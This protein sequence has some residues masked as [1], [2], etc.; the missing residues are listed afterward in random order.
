VPEVNID[1]RIL[2]KFRDEGRILSEPKTVMPNANT[3]GQGSVTVRLVN[4]RTPS[5]QDIVR[6]P[7]PP[8]T[9]NLFRGGTGKGR[10]R[11]Q[12][13]NDWLE[14]ALPILQGMR[15]PPLTPFYLKITIFDDGSFSQQS[16]CD[17]RIKACQDALVK[18]GVIPGDSVGDGLHGVTVRYMRYTP[19]EG[20]G[21]GA[22][23]QVH[24]TEASD[25]AETE[26]D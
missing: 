18:A 15:G 4:G 2:Q 13:Y 16:D 25:G 21:D 9:N 24:F 19:P 8:S 14:E 3:G 5:S 6:L 10:Y 1:P 7:I 26:D 22:Y 17:N 20:G 11:I 23:I 12:E